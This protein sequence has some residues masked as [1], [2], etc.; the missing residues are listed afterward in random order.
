MYHNNDVTVPTA[1]RG[2]FVT[3][4]TRIQLAIVERQ[5]EAHHKFD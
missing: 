5:T 1:K 2:V 4:D 3:P